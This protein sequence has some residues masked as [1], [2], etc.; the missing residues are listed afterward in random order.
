MF[1]EKSLCFLFLKAGISH[2]G[3][4]ILLTAFIHIEFFAL[5][6]GKLE[7]REIAIIKFGVIYYC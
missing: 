5:I 1:F 7:V 2:V 3:V 6:A 4:S